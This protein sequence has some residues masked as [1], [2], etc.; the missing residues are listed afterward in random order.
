MA[1]QRAPE[2]MKGDRDVCMAAV[3]QKWNALELASD[4]MRRNEEVVI[5]A[6]KQYI[7][8]QGQSVA[9]DGWSW[10]WLPNDMRKNNR[11]RKAAGI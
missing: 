8:R 11:V 5:A 4:D 9:E 10:S 1:L 3:A 6:I 7:V 2:G